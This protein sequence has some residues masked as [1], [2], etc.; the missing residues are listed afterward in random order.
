VQSENNLKIKCSFS[1]TKGF[2][3]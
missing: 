2:S 1:T 3:N